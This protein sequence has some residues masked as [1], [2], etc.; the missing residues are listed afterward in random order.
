MSENGGK[1]NNKGLGLLRQ[2]VSG[3][4]KLFGSGTIFTVIGVVILVLIAIVIILVILAMA[5]SVFNKTGITEDGY[6]VPDDIAFDLYVKMYEIDDIRPFIEPGK[7][8]DTSLKL[9]GSTVKTEVYYGARIYS[10][11]G[12]VST[13]TKRGVN[14][15]NL[16]LPSQNLTVYIKN[17]THISKNLENAIRQMQL[18]EWLEETD[19]MLLNWH[20]EFKRVLETGEELP[21]FPI[22]EYYYDEEYEEI[23][24]EWQEEYEEALKLWKRLPSPPIPEEYYREHT[25]DILYGEIKNGTYKVKYYCSS[26]EPV[27]YAGRMLNYNRDDYTYELSSSEVSEIQSEIASAPLT[28][29]LDV[30]LYDGDG[31][32]YNRFETKMLMMYIM[33]FALEGKYE[34]NMGAQ[35]FIE[36]CVQHIGLPYVWGADDLNVACD[37]SGYTQQTYLKYLGLEIAGTARYQ[38]NDGT[39]IPASA[40]RPGDLVFFTTDPNRAVEIGSLAT[41]VGIYIGN[42]MFVHSAGES[43]GNIISRFSGK[44]E[45]ICIGGRRYLLSTDYSFDSWDIGIEKITRE[46]LDNFASFIAAEKIINN[47]S[48]KELE[49]I[50]C[51]IFNRTISGQFGTYTIKDTINN[52]YMFESVSNGNYL[53][54]APTNDVYKIVYRVVCGIDVTR[55]GIYMKYI[56]DVNTDMSD[57][58][59]VATIGNM[60]FYKDYSNYIEVITNE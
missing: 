54:Y 25:D 41:H 4:T 59:H 13:V 42:D 24:S 48:E 17:I 45:N 16:T 40:L 44:Y 35:E 39:P 15:Y 3:A 32:R 9:I 11:A 1:N 8:A 23:L 49:A 29:T 21:E 53:S 37:C 7:V 55:S 5:W 33:S 56:D 2:A 20:E 46:D 22:S 27:A 19:E 34:G 31:N 57:K 6:A 47:L 36:N 14:K 60:E 50:A 10:I 30:I 18:D 58:Q 43:S 51:Y 12:I 38:I 52:S 28:L 26:S